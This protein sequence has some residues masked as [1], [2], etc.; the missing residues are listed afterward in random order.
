[1]VTCADQQQKGYSLAPSLQSRRYHA[2]IW[3]RV[4]SGSHAS[5]QRSEG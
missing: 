5:R 4:G 1:M 2:E 3:D